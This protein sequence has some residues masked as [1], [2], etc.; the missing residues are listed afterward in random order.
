[1]LRRLL[2]LAFLVC[3]IAQAAGQPLSVLSFNIWGGGLNRGESIDAT[4]AAIRAADADLVGLQEVR[5]ESDP[6][7]G[8]HCPPVGETVSVALAREL[9]YHHYDQRK[10]NDALWANAV[11]SR[12]PILG[13]SENDLGVQVD[14]LGRKVVLFN[15]HA[16]DYPYQPYQ[17]LRI[18]YGAAPFLE[19]A[20]QAVQSARQARQSA[21]ELVRADLRFAEGADLV[22]LTG[23]F[24]EPSRHDWTARAVAAGRH[25]V[26]VDWPLTGAIE[27]LGFTDAYRAAHPDEVANPGF[28]W[29]PL[30]SEPATDDHADRIDY[31]F[32]RG[33]TVKVSGAKV[34]GESS[35]QA[36]LVV[37]PWPSDHRA[38]LAELEF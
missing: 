15:I 4:V 2:W 1:M 17:L 6:C 31:V 27:Q 35:D 24:N 22:V 32:V 34:V 18:P 8:E 23:D 19:T 33:P 37:S 5:G 30:I 21:L 36:D 14:V 10:V 13:A 9:G 16:T 12:Y 26:A 20:A 25:P 3:P 11:L 29:S 28:T 38:V 7:T